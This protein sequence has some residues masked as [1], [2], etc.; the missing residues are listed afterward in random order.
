ML[1]PPGEPSI[2]GLAVVSGLLALVWHPMREQ[3]ARGASLR[4]SEQAWRDS[5]HVD[6]LGPVPS[7]GLTVELLPEV[8]QLL[9]PWTELQLVLLD[10]IHV[11]LRQFALVE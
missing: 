2:A 7:R 10:V 6:K 9:E 3:V 5:L 8:E 4:F 11:V 1:R